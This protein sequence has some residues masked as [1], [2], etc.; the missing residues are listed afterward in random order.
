MIETFHLVSQYLAAASISFKSKKDD[1]SHTNLIWN[2]ESSSLSTQSLNDDGI[3]MSLS[4]R[5]FKLTWNDKTSTKDFDLNGKSHAEILKWIVL[6][7]EASTINKTYQYQFHYDLPYS[8]VENEDIFNAGD[9]K[10]VNEIIGNLDLAQKEFK[11]FLAASELESDLRVWPHHFDLGGFVLLQNGTGLGFG[12]GIPD[13][14]SDTPYIYVSGYKGHDPVS[15]DSFTELS[16]GNWQ[17]GSWNGA[18]LPSI[19][20]SDGAVY[21]FLQQAYKSFE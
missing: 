14:V 17:S 10:E 5:S 20:F 7:V 21:S 12:L 6:M 1:D 9:A 2:V 13:S 19:E 4:F 15:T 18:V 11:E 3:T 16:I 8:S